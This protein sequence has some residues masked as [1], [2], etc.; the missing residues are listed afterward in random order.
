MID[1]LTHD[2]HTL[3]RD[4][5]AD[6]SLWRDE[7]DN[8]LKE[9]SRASG[10]LRRAERALEAHAQALDRHTLD[11]LTEEREVRRHKRAMGQAAG[12]GRA[13][14]VLP[15]GDH[16]AEAER[17]RNMRDVHERLKEYHHAILARLSVLLRAIAEPV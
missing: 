14:P 12:G 6:V 16:T 4:W 8:W 1:T 9:L 11:L 5:E 15:P 10:D 13:E 3:H 7:L 2:F 17:Y